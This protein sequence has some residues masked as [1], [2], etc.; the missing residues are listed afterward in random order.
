MTKL[1]QI[2]E[3]MSDLSCAELDEVREATYQKQSE[4]EIT[5]PRCNE[6]ITPYG[7]VDSKQYPDGW[8]PLVV[9]DDGELFYDWDHSDMKVGI[10][11]Y[12]PACELYIGTR[13]DIQEIWDKERN[14]DESK[15]N[16]KISH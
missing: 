5:C 13:Q 9:E 12:C 4:I 10:D 1:E 7:T 14:T 2:L 6:R 15:K 8:V 3:M 16:R 11:V